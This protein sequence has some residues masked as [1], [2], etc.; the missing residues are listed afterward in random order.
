LFLKKNESI[1]SLNENHPPW[2]LMQG[3]KNYKG[4]VEE[5]KFL[6]DFYAFQLNVIIKIKYNDNLLKN[7]CNCREH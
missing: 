6:N 7:H 1:D 2:P 3:G 4:G 5:L